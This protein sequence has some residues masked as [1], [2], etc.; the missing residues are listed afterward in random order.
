[1]S[2]IAYPATTKRFV[3]RNTDGSVLHVGVTEPQQV[4]TT[5][6]PVLDQADD[7]NGLLNLLSGFSDQ[8]PPLP[9]AGSEAGLTQGEI[10]DWNGTLVM[11]R[12]SHTR[13]EHDP[14]DVPAL[15]LVYRPDA[16]D[17]L[18]WVSGEWVYV[19]T[20]RTYGG[21]TYSCLQAH[22]TRDGWE[23]PNDGII[24]VLWEVYTEP[25]GG[26]AWVDSGETVVSLVGASTIQ[27][28]DTAPF[29]ADQLIR[30]DGTDEATIDRIHQPGAPGIIVIVPHVSVSGGESIEIWQ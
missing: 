8:F 16:S 4:T 18:E 3:A 25:G 5:G 19:G 27:V 14:A 20:L 26:E 24:N 2:E 12:Q 29:A 17:V 9:A 11:V 23:P 10:Y 7:E 15:F 13:T 1:M 22:Q 30:I 28:S 6:Q 21:E